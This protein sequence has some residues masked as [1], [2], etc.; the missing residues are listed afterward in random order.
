MFA[1]DGLETLH[2]AQA[3]D[4]WIQDIKF[5]PDGSTLAVASHDCNMYVACVAVAVCG[6]VCGCVLMPVGVCSCGGLAAA[7]AHRLVNGCSYLHDT[8]DGYP[9]RATCTGH[10][11]GVAH[12]D[13]TSDSTFLR[14]SGSAAS[15]ELLFFDA[16][17]GER[18]PD[19][20]TVL[21][22]VEWAS[23]TATGGWAVAGVASGTTA[24]AAAHSLPLVGAVNQDGRVA[25]HRYPAAPGS[26]GVTLHGHTPHAT[27]AGWSFDDAFLYTTGGNDRCIMQWRQK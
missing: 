9:L 6:S 2:A 14:S 20:A 1:R 27:N 7:R 13:F 11:T 15:G 26:I 4:Q 12:V 8:M 3:G 21:A 22:E 25:V 19:G 23:H 10:K 5:S 18:D 16:T 17:S 24:V